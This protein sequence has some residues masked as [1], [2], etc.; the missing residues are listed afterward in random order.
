MVDLSELLEKTTV[1][2]LG[3][4]MVVQ[5][6]AKLGWL[7]S[8]SG[9]RSGLLVVNLAARLDLLDWMLVEW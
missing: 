7:A 6:V 8:K 1:D 3:F 2:Y 9:K 5:K 4:Q